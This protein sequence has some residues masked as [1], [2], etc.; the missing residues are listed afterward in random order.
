MCGKRSCPRTILFLGFQVM[1]LQSQKGRPSQSGSKGVEKE[2]AE[3]GAVQD[4]GQLERR[5]EEL[6]LGLGSKAEQVG[7]VHYQVEGMGLAGLFACEFLYGYVCLYM[8]L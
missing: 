6:E 5:M 7:G 1:Q 2:E 4:A 8:C 3:S